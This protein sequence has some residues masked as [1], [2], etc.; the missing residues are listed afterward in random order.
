MSRVVDSYTERKSRIEQQLASVRHPEIAELL[1]SEIT[2]LTLASSDDKESRN[3]AFKALNT[4]L[5]KNRD[6]LLLR[7]A[8]HVR[9]IQNLGAANQFQYMELL[10]R[11]W[12]ITTQT[13]EMEFANVAEQYAVITMDKAYGMA[14]EGKAAKAYAT[15]YS[16]IR[17]TNDLEAHYQFI[18]LGLRPDLGK[19]E[20]LER[21]YQIL[22]K[23]KLLGQ[24]ENY[25][26]ALRL[27]LEADPKNPAATNTALEK[28]LALLE[29]MQ[30]RGLNPAVRD[31]LMG[32]IHHQRL[33]QSQQGY[34]YDKAAFQKAHYH[35]IMALDLGRDNSRISASVWENL[36]WL[37]LDVRNHALAV[38][39]FRRRL[40]LPFVTP[41]D[42]AR[43]RLG[44]ARAL[45]ANNQ[46]EKALKQATAA[47]ELAS[48][49][50]TLDATPFL[51]KAAFYALQAADYETA[52]EY[53]R[54]LLADGK[55]LSKENHAKALLG[56]SYALMKSGDT[57]GAT[58]HFNQLLA[59]TKKLKP[60]PVPPH[61]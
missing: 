57:E 16:A 45:F 14:A 30:R 43:T 36:A 15:F 17:Q 56:Y 19:R 13:S 34:H 28:A 1:R 38:D 42:E 48:Q 6:D 25:V 3:Q 60:L 31:L 5:K 46:P 29:P 7:K 23:Q 4:L 39:F 47:V 18:T 40:A 51:E 44:F 32:Y 9:A 22:K 58:S 41:E 54:P 55:K 53:W 20:N 33:R 35:Y 8:M 24:N 61:A 49:S 12:L 2:T 11:H 37:H 21:S 50:H 52:I 59:L 10:S 27:I 26:K